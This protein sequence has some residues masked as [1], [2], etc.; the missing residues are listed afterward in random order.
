MQQSEL[1]DDPA[2]SMNIFQSWT[3]LMEL[4]STPAGRGSLGQGLSCCIWS[5]SCQLSSLLSHSLFFFPGNSSFLLKSALLKLLSTCSQRW[6]I[7]LL[8]K[9]QLLAEP[10]KTMYSYKSAGASSQWECK[11]LGCGHLILWLL[12]CCKM[13]WCWWI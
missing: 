1:R 12:D 9:P 3:W 7:V 6:W 5:P 4:N 8:Q 11:S 13:S 10:I 2:G